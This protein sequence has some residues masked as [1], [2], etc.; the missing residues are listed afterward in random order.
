M[1]KILKS[2]ATTEKLLDP[3]DRVTVSVSH[4][5]YINGDQSWIKLEIN[6]QVRDAETSGEAIGRVHGE[7]LHHLMG[8]IED[9]VA[10]VESQGEK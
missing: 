1:T 4:Q 5:I 8:I 10:M 9:N 3:G 6:G 2:E 7:V